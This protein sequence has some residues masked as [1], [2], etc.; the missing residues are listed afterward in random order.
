VTIQDV[1]WLFLGGMIGVLST[2]AVAGAV[3]VLPKLA[4]KRVVGNRAAVVTDPRRG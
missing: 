4:R 2:Y 1:V 3:I